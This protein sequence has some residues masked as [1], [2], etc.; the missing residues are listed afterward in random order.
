MDIRYALSLF[1][2]IPIGLLTAVLMR[3]TSKMRPFA[4]GLCAAVS[5]GLLIVFGPLNSPEAFFTGG[6]KEFEN[7]AFMEHA[8]LFPLD[9]SLGPIVEAIATQKGI[10]REKDKSVRLGI[11]SDTLEWDWNLS[12]RIWPQ[13]FEA[14]RGIWVEPT[15]IVISPQACSEA[16]ENKID[17]LVKAGATAWETVPCAQ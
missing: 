15:I 5:L 4:A 8:N 10:G 2:S 7:K 9:Q 3:T 6:L 14:H 11:L 13:E 12:M 17:V 1:L 16:A